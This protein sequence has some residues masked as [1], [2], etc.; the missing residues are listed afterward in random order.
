MAVFDLASSEIY[1][2]NNLDITGHASSLAYSIIP[3]LTVDETD[4]GMMRLLLP[5]TEN[6]AWKYTKY[7]LVF[8]SAPAVQIM[9]YHIFQRLANKAKELFTFCR[10]SKVAGGLAGQL[11]EEYAHKRLMKGGTF[12]LRY[13]EASKPEKLAVVHLVCFI[14][15]RH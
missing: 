2:L 1:S 5:I 10:G 13:L 11:F 3:D 15:A 14:Y 8:A 4:Y 9:S 6:A 7:R 12:K